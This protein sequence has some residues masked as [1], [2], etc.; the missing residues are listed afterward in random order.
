[1]PH[2]PDREQGHHGGMIHAGGSNNKIGGRETGGDN[3]YNR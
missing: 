2:H 3:S 1:V